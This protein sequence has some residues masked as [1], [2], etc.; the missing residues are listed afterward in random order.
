MTRFEKELS[1][2][3][4][5]YWKGEAEKELQKI[6]AELEAGEITIDGK[7]VARNC[8][9]RVLQRDMEEKVSFVTDRIDRKATARAREEEV[10]RQLEELRRTAKPMSAG[11][12]QRLR[13][14][15]GPGQTVV[16]L[17]TGEVIRT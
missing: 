6:R 7:G 14:E 3:L 10:R 15:I 13:R 9:G 4:G 8:I 11:E 17:I 16:D 2:A 12:K 5:A 1:G